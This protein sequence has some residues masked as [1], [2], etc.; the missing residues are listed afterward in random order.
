MS[1]DQYNK[2]MSDMLN[3][4]HALA[5]LRAELEGREGK[6]CRQC[7]KFGHLARNCRSAKK[8]GKGRVAENKF[9]VLRS[10]VMQC[11]VREMRRQEVV[12]DVVK[13][14]GCGKKG[15]KKWECPRKKERSKSEET[16][17]PREVWEKVKLHSGAKGLPPRGAKMNMEGWVIRREVVTFV[18]CH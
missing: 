5:K 4:R 12:R 7:G 16:A 9:E 18:E 13:C 2:L 14:F 17:P 3:K 1:L 6:L 10:R 8:Q 15:H 11:G